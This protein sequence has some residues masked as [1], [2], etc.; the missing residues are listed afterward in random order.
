MNLEELWRTALGTIELQVSKTNFLNWFKNST[1]LEKNEEA[2]TIGL[3]NNF[4][5][6][7]VENRGHKIVLKTL[8][9]LD[10]TTKRITYVVVNNNTKPILAKTTANELV[11]Q[12]NPA[13]TQLEFLEF[14]V[15][16]QTS[17][18]PKYTLQSFAVGK[19]N[20]LAYA[21]T[22]AIIEKIGTVYNPLFISGGVGVG[23]THLI[24]AA[25][26]E[27]K[28]RYQNQ[29][30]VRYISSEKFINDVVSGI[31]KKVMDSVKEKYRDIDVLI[32][33]DIQYIAGKD[34]TQREFFST[35]EVLYQNNKQI[36]LTSDREPAYI[37]GLE[38]RLKSRFSGGMVA[39][40]DPPEY[41]LRLAVLKNKLLE[42]KIDLKL[43]IIELIS[44]KVQKNFRELEG[45]LNRILFYQKNKSQEL[46]IENVE[47][48]L[49]D[50][51]Q[52]PSYNIDPNQIVKCVANYFD[53]TVADLIGRSRKKEL[54]EPRQI[55]M[56][57]LRNVLDLSYPFI[58]EKLGKRDHTTVIYSCAKVEQ[59]INKNHSLNRKVVLIKDEIS[60]I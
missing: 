36:I 49:S 47:Q 9:D 19:S 24:Q 4:A 16:P 23:K 7:W 38:E 32:I 41:E 25:G 60:K 48:L 2:T 17:L 58:G 51:V 50:A 52:K 31:H 37:D 43:E 18:N 11:S 39:I 22:L 14:R 8:R 13:E 59:E 44:S 10:N 6:E 27:I 20:E 33:D 46:T 15:D 1:L 3:P 30:R 12:I 55:A 40:I 56:Y 35:F 45:V 54:V 21:A 26:N 28:K 57:L 53:I 5:K 42:R 34:A 29:V